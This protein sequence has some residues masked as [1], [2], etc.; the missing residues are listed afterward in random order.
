MA[1]LINNWVDARRMVCSRAW[2]EGYESFRLGAPPEFDG[3]KSKCLSYEYGRL[4]AALLR[5]E[6]AR[7]LRV[8][9]TRPLYDTYIPYLAE[10]LVRAA[11]GRPA[12]PR[13][14]MQ[15]IWP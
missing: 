8:S 11:Q 4:T 13:P 1:Q 5:S 15:R 3:H 2:R 6:G 9:T 10:A 12:P 7:L 14:E